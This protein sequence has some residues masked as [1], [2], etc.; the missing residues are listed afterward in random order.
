[1]LISIVIYL[2]LHLTTVRFPEYNIFRDI[3]IVF[4]LLYELCKTIFIPLPIKVVLISIIIFLFRNTLV[5]LRYLV[6]AIINK[7]CNQMFSKVFTLKHN[8]K[9]F[10]NYR[11]I[12]VSN[13]PYTHI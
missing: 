2:L 8:F 12:I 10:P 6:S 5:F 11:S 1:M 3:A 4:I 13:Y 9:N 7:N